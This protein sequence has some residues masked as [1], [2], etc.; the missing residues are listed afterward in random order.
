MIS[1]TSSV[2]VQVRNLLILH[3]AGRHEDALQGAVRLA[4]Q[5]QHS[6]LALNLLG[7]FH[8][9]A[10]LRTGDSS[11]EAA[12]NHGMCAVGA[13][14]RATEAAPNCLKTSAA[15]LACL[16]EMKLHLEADEEISRVEELLRVEELVID[17]PQIHHVAFDL[18]GEKST[19]EYR[20]ERAKD[21]FTQQKFER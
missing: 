11:S 16:S 4:E 20:I 21:D 13:Y 7:Y 9:D 1:A 17:D 15:Y 3:R 5:L 14:K 12:R 18:E 10:C 8:I 2:R 6:A 19:K